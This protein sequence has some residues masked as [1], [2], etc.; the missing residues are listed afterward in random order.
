MTGPEWR[1][2]VGYLPAESHWWADSVK[3]HYAG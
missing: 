1:R 3:E 2:K